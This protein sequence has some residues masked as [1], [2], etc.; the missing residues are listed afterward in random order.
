MMYLRFKKPEKS[1]TRSDLYIWIV[2]DTSSI[3]CFDV[4]AAAEWF[5]KDK[6]DY[7]NFTE[8]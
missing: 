1:R 7:T 2:L 8:E 5:K 4:K 3:F 6:W